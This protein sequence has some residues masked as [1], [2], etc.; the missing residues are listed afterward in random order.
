MTRH[1]TKTR[2]R[3]DKKKSSSSDDD[4]K[5]D[6]KNKDKAKRKKRARAHASASRHEVSYTFVLAK[7]FN[8][9]K[10]VM[11]ILLTLGGEKKVIFAV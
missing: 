4:S 11:D 6:A 3:R 2:K 10:N 9:M 1:D 5:R 8:Y 7:L